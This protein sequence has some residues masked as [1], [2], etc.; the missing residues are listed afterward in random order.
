MPFVIAGPVELAQGALEVLNLALVINLLP[1]GEFECFEDFLHIV[2][3]VFK[4]LDDAG[5]L[6]DGV[7]DGGSLVRHFGRLMLLGFFDGGLG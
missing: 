4:L 2:K 6:L 7:A 3:G 1:F 5:D